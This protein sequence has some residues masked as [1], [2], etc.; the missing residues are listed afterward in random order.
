[1][2]TRFV[3]VV[4]RKEL[5]TR[6]AAGAA[7]PIR[8]EIDLGSHFLTDK[9][10]ND[11]PLESIPRFA[12]SDIHTRFEAYHRGGRSPLFVML[13]CRRAQK[14]MKPFLEFFLPFLPACVSFGPLLVLTGVLLRT[15]AK[16]ANAIQ[17]KKSIALLYSGTL[18]ITYALTA[19]YWK[20]IP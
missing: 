7:S 12:I 4:A 2:T 16:G 8:A 14:I 1:M 20:I 19:F 11:I 17:N 3:D 10:F 18:M 5:V 13:S 9:L 6:R 15:P